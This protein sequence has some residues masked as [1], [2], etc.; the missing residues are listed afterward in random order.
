MRPD[1]RL[2]TLVGRTDRE[3]CLCADPP[4]MGR[5]HPARAAPRRVLRTRRRTLTVGELLCVRW[6]ALTCSLA[7]MR[8]R[9]ATGQG[10]RPACPPTVLAGAEALLTHTTDPRV[11]AYVD[12][13]AGCQQAICREVLQRST[14]PT[15][16]SPRPSSAPAS[17]LRPGGLHLRAA[18]SQRP[19]Q[20]LPLRRGILSGSEMIITG[21]SMVSA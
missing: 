2:F 9:F 17:P 10:V 6:A 14:P 16:R 15:R 12:A 21:G 7:T 8:Q 5:H 3:G 11:D 20:R 13:L 1:R 4:V 19:R 18:G